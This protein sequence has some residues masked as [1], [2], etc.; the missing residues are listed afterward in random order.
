MFELKTHATLQPL[1]D[2]DKGVF[3]SLDA[4][5]CTGDWTAFRTRM[6]D[7]IDVCKELLFQ[8]IHTQIPTRVSL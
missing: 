7:G 6:F 5:G 1:S 4:V 3:L 2:S 8:S